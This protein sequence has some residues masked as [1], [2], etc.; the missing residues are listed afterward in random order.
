MSSCERRPIR[1][2]TLNFLKNQF[3]FRFDVVLAKIAENFMYLSRF[4]N[5]YLSNF[6]GWDILN[7]TQCRM[8]KALKLKYFYLKIDD[9]FVNIGIEC[10]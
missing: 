9:R 3:F 1:A 4:M 5:F 8:N 6:V 10:G 2:S 7:G